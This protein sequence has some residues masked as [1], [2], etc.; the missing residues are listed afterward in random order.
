MSHLP[1]N[2]GNSKRERETS[3]SWTTIASSSAFRIADESR[4]NREYF[5]C[6]TR[7]EMAKWMN[8]MGLAAI[9]FN[10][11]DSK[12][13][14]FHKGFVDSRESSPASTPNLSQ[15][16][17]ATNKH[18]RN[19]PMGSAGDS[20]ND[21]DKESVTSWQK[22]NSHHSS[23]SDTESSREKVKRRRTSDGERNERCRRALLIRTSER[24]SRR[25]LDMPVR[26]R[27]RSSPIR[28]TV[29]SN[30]PRIASLDKSI[31]RRTKAIIGPAAHLSAIHL[32]STI[33]QR[34]P[35]SMPRP[36][37]RTPILR[38]NCPING[39]SPTSRTSNSTV[40]RRSVDKQKGRRRASIVCLASSR[41]NAAILFSPTRFDWWNS[42]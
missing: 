16:S 2:E 33:S 5:Y 41:K 38:V 8:K 4:K 6:S 22:C 15:G 11:D 17:P 34:P 14:G 13:G 9:N 18:L 7:D 30:P 23:V 40:R 1:P 42:R 21:S 26:P 24:I 12:I 37:S 29:R 32:R 31:L 36:D 20:E 25:L 3:D 39:C 10:M 27:H 35:T 19:A 28:T